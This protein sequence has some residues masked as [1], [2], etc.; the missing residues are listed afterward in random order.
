[1]RRLLPA[2]CRSAKAAGEHRYYLN[3]ILWVEEA[4][5]KCIDIPVQG[6]G[7]NGSVNLWVHSFLA[8]ELV[9]E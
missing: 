4:K 5:A 9:D 6:M 1:M 8:S 2:L 3:I 7:L